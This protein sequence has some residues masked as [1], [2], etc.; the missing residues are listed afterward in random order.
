MPRPRARIDLA[1]L[2]DAF[3]ADGLHGTA[4]DDIARAVGVTKPT[5]Y[6]HGTTKSTLFLFA[7]ES[8]VERVLDRLHAAERTTVGRNPRARAT[9]AAHAMLDHAA[10]RPHGARL[11]THT[12]RHRNSEIATA[13]DAALKRIPDYLTT[14]L[15]RDL[16]NHDLDPSLA[17]HI[18]KALHGATASL[19]D[20]TTGERRPARAVLAS[21]AASLIPELPPPTEEW[22][23]AS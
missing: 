18:A 23:T 16:I 9:A 10:A 15:R 21:L 1:A 8:E 22:P 2:A 12:A 17:P 11:L 20:L 4:T 19:S 3:A 5:L 13:V 7:V 14:T 6:A